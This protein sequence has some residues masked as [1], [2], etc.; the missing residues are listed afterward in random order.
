MRLIL[1]LAGLNPRPGDQK[2]AVL[3]TWPPTFNHWKAGCVR[4]P[5]FYRLSGIP[6][7][8]H[9]AVFS[10]TTGWNLTKLATGL[11]FK[12]R[13]SPSVMLLATLAMSMGFAMLHLWLH[14]LVVKCK[15]KRIKKCKRSNLDHIR[16]TASNCLYPK[17]VHWCWNI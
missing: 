4:A 1:P 14:I 2:L 7:S 16:S 12:V 6:P 3:T 10:Q 11:P 5:L 8:V 9:H 13:A 17:Q 15:T